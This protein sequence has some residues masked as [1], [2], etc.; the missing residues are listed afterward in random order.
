MTLCKFCITSEIIQLKRYYHIFCSQFF[1]YIIFCICNNIFQMGWN[2]LWK[3]DFILHQ[4]YLLLRRSSARRKGM[5]GLACL[6]WR[7]SARRK[8]MLRSCVSS[9]TFICPAERYVAVLL[10]FFVVYLPGGKVCC[11]LAC[12]FLRLSARRKG[13]LRSCLSSST[14][15]C[16][17]E[18]YIAVLRVFFDVYLPGLK[19]CC[20]LAC[21]LR[22]LSVRRKGIL[23][24][25]VSSSTFICPAERYVFWALAC[26]VPR[27]I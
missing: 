1:I 19:V 14:F 8:G 27:L 2:T 4:R 5:C 13:M 22:R 24:S 11:G 3:N 26:Q 23:R 12:L 20:G 15:I 7:S 9:S 16:P 18:R 25:C 17:A 6:L 10:V 21:L